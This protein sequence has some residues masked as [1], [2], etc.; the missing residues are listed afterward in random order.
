ML[1]YAAYQLGHYRRVKQ[2]HAQLHFKLGLFTFYSFL[3]SAVSGTILEVPKDELLNLLHIMSSFA[4]LIFI[5][6][7]LVLVLR[8]AGLKATGTR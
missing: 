6:A 3:I 2:Y 8:L 5:F 4:F 7:H 1:P